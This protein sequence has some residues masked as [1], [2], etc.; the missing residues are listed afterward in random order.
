MNG[1]RVYSSPANTEASGE[2]KAFYCQRDGGPL[3]VG[4]ILF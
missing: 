3:T 2:T 1:L 4:V